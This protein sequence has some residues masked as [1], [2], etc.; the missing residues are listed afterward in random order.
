MV[1]RS[2]RQIECLGDGVTLQDAR[3]PLIDFLCRWLQGVLVRVGR[4]ERRAEEWIVADL[5]LKLLNF[6]SL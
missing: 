6:M 4:H 5:L 2:K 1:G 3:L